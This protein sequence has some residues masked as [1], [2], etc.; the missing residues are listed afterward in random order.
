MKPT[1]Q[2]VAAAQALQKAQQ[3]FAQETYVTFHQARVILNSGMIFFQLFYF[4]AY[5]LKDISNSLFLVAANSVHER[6]AR[7]HIQFYGGY[8][9]AILAAVMLLLHQQVEFGK[10]PQNRTVL[11]L[12]IRKWLS[13]PDECHTAFVFDRVAHGFISRRRK[14][15]AIHKDNRI[16][17]CPG[18]VLIGKWF[19]SRFYVL[20]QPVPLKREIANISA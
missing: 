5:F 1:A 12:I 14:G 17:S 6:V 7:F 2:Q 20:T 8:T 16:K 19:V 18:A 9:C 4:M 15:K 11:A 13:Q 3:Q 10:T